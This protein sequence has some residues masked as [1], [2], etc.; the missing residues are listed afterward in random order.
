MEFEKKPIDNMNGNNRMPETVNPE[1]NIEEEKSS[2]K[3]KKEEKNAKKEAA[4]RKK[5]EAKA[6]KAAEAEAKA[7][8]KRKKKAAKKAAKEGKITLGKIIVDEAADVISTHDRIQASVDRFF[9]PQEDR[10]V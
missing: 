7:A 2:K 10:L 9:T 6:K 3:K 4:A 1:E 5:A 8:E